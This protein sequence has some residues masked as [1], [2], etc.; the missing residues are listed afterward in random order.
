[1][2][3]LQSNYISLGKQIVHITQAHGIFFP[4]HQENFTFR[5]HVMTNFQV[6]SLLNHE[7]TCVPFLSVL[8]PSEI[9]CC[10]TRISL[11][12]SFDY[13]VNEMFLFLFN[14]SANR[15]F[16]LIE[17]INLP[18]DPTFHPNPLNFFIFFCTSIANHGNKNIKFIFY[19]NDFI[20]VHCNT[21]G[22]M[23]QY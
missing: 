11:M 3:L 7:K 6:Y 22:T 17:K 23:Y 9:N 12:R 1:M 15:Y 10:A 14:C 21:N 20:R 8:L 4:L 2:E 16:I 13:I 19:K 5:S 18:I